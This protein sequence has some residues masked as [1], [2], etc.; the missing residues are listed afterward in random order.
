MRAISWWSRLMA[1]SGRTITLKSTIRPAS[2]H[3][4]MSTP[5]ITIPSISVT[6]SSIASRSPT[7]SRT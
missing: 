4:M 5:L 3:W 6:N 2:F 7:I 1:F